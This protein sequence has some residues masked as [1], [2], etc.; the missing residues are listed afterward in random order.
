MKKKRGMAESTL[1]VL[2]ITIICIGFVGLFINNYMARQSCVQKV[3]LCKAS[4]FLISGAKKASWGALS[5]AKL[6]CPVCVPGSSGDIKSVNKK[7]VLKQ[8][9]EHLRYCWYKSGGKNNRV[10]EALFGSS[11][12][13]LV[14]S[15]FKLSND[16]SRVDL[17]DF[18]SKT[19]INSG[20]GQGKTYAEY[21]NGGF[22]NLNAFFSD[23]YGFDWEKQFKNT[24]MYVPI[25]DEFQFVKNQNYQVIAYN[26]FFG[27]DR[28]INNILMVD[29]DMLRHPY[30]EC[31]VYH[32]QKE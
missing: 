32:Y 11:S 27:S 23:L 22:V 3:E 13:C 2:I 7:E 19:K 25:G 10:G 12:V 5:P 15:E 24:V 1:A 14:C 30:L 6:D 31:D 8:I 21:L 9:A 28:N 26:K 4:S 18:L 16:V 29:S 17:L 20:A